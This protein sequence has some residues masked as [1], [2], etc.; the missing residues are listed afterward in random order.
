[1]CG[2]VFNYNESGWSPIRELVAVAVAYSQSHSQS[3]ANAPR[4]ATGLLFALLKNIPDKFFANLIGNKSVK[5]KYSYNYNIKPTTSGNRGY[6][7]CQIDKT[8]QQIVT[9]VFLF[10]HN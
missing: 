8:I 5:L 4:Q 2:K 9:K 10:R 6:Q 1:M 3:A 7:C